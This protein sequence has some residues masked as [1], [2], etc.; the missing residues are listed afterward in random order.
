MFEGYL[1]VDSLFYVFFFVLNQENTG[2][3]ELTTSAL[4][5]QTC[6]NRFYITKISA[7]IQMSL[8]SF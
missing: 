6:V 1:F 3:V 4:L 2:L 5:I 7:F 8:F